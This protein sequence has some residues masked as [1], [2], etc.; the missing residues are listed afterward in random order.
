MVKGDRLSE[1]GRFAMLAEDHPLVGKECTVCQQPFEPGD[2]VA[3]IDSGEPSDSLTVQADVA[4]E[5][6]VEF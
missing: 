6:C 3:L 5:V 4:H 2:L 1:P